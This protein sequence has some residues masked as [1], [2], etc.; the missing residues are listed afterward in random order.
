MA[1]SLRFSTLRGKS[2][3]I[4]F[5][6]VLCERRFEFPLARVGFPYSTINERLQKYK[7]L[8]QT[9]YFQISGAMSGIPEQ[10]CKAYTTPQGVFL[11]HI[12]S[13]T[14]LSVPALLSTLSIV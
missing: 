4:N 1:E 9:L 2:L 14:L 12:V 5:P 13:P 11:L 8:P 7:P 6:S 10:S 3:A